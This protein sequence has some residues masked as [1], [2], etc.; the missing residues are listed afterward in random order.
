M[1]E[2][3]TIKEY[4]R[5]CRCADCKVANNAY[6]KEYR[7]RQRSALSGVTAKFAAI[8]A[9]HLGWMDRARC[10]GM[11][12]DLFFPSRGTDVEAVRAICAECEVAEECLAFA[13]RTNQDTGVWGG[14]SVRERDAMRSLLRIG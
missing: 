10:K 6:M 14:K 9:G 12:T 7:E 3:G 11:D 5:G 8:D 13:L 4:R 1:R 2:H